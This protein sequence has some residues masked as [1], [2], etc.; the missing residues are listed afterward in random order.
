MAG[1]DKIYSKH[2]TYPSTDCPQ[3]NLLLEQL[4]PGD[5]LVVT[6]LNRFARSATKGSELVKELIERGI[7]VY[8]SNF[9]LMA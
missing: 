1:C 9:K 5:I 2:F 4:L 8:L 3:F 6:K 7:A